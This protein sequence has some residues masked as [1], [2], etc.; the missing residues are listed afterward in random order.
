MKTGWFQVNGNWY[1]AYSSG[2]L[3]VNTTVDG[4]SV[5]YNGEWVR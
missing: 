2:A 4:Y 5:N 1:Y 3:A